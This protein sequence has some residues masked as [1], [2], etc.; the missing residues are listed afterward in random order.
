MRWTSLLA[1]AA[2]LATLTACG[3]G[4]NRVTGQVRI[5]SET[6]IAVGQDPDGTPACKGAKGYEDIIGGDLVVVRNGDGKPVAETRLSQG[7]PSEDGASCTFTWDIQGLPEFKS[8]TVQ[9]EE[10]DPVP[11]TLDELRNE[12]FKPVLVL[13]GG[14]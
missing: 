3:G 13:K 9:V 2:V 7:V 14:S 11:Y 1:A 5:D 6:S 12:D 8:Y 4:A 10:R